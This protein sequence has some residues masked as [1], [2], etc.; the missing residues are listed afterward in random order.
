MVFGT[1]QPSEVALMFVVA[2][3]ARAASMRHPLLSPVSATAD[4]WIYTAVAV[5]SLSTFALLF[6]PSFDLKQ[7]HYRSNMLTYVPLFVWII[8]LLLV[9]WELPKKWRDGMYLKFESVVATTSS[10]TLKKWETVQLVVVKNHSTKRLT[11]SHPRLMI[12]VM[13]SKGGTELLKTNGRINSRVV[14]LNT[15]SLQPNNTNFLTYSFDTILSTAM[16]RV[17]VL[18]VTSG[19]EDVVIAVGFF[20]MSLLTEG[21]TTQVVPLKLPG[22]QKPFGSSTI[23]CSYGIPGELLA[24]RE[25]SSR[26]PLTAIMRSLCVSDSRLPIDHN[27]TP[28]YPSVVCRFASRPQRLPQDFELLRCFADCVEA[29]SQEADRGNFSAVSNLLVNHVDPRFLDLVSWHSLTPFT[30]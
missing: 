8:P 23:S 22:T 17:Q 4:V 9:M 28:L 5:F 25:R 7:H 14:A 11:H 6:A 24:I 15:A 20:S 3:T 26:N 2:S 16:F 27:R 1:D 12:T 13:K 30:L 21:E 19:G 18:D 10:N 29:T